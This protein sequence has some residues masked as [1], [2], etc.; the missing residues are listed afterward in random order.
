[1]KD[2]NFAPMSNWLLRFHSKPYALWRKVISA[3]YEVTYAG[4]IPIKSKHSNFKA[5]WSSITKGLNWVERNYKW[6]VNNG[7]NIS[8]WFAN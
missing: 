6:E 4:E 1:M 2:I 7:E 8:F 3:K 5:P